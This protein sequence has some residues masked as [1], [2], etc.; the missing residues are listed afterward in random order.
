[1]LVA[2]IAWALLIFAFSAQNGEES[3]ETSGKVVTLVIRAIQPD[4]GNLPI[5]DQIAFRD[6]V[7]FI[8]RK[9]AHFSEYAV[10]GLLLCGMYASFGKKKLSLGLFSFLTGAAY[11]ATDEFHQMFSVGRSPQIIDVGIDSAGVLCG[12]LIFFA[13]NLLYNQ[14]KRRQE[15]QSGRS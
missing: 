8:I 2:V 10:L 14:W 4:Y 11:A 13:G 1:M 12:C 5:R 3:S 15:S 7:S 9:L 6:R